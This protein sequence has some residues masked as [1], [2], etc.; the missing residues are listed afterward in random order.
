MRSILIALA[1]TL[2]ACRYAPPPIPVA[3]TPS[4]VAALAGDWT[5]DY[6]SDESGRLGTITFS[7]R[8]GADSA[9]GDVLMVP[10][11]NWNMP[12]PVDAKQ[13]HFL[14]AHSER[15]LAVRFV[16]IEGGAVFGMLEPYV[17]PDWDCVVTTTF[18][19]RREGN[20]ISGTF[21]TRNEIGWEQHGRWRVERAR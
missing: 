10:R 12:L 13:D 2:A 7:L 15:S 18:F 9:F 11:D 6:R 5:G 8:A 17:A 21:V 14:H 16:R 1:A 3:G 19:G 20:V 4:Q